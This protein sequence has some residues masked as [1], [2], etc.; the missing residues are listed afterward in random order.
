MKQFLI[1]ISLFLLQNCI[2][3]KNT[4]IGN[5]YYDQNDLQFTFLVFDNQKI[6]IFLKNYQSFDFQ[7]EK[8]KNDLKKLSQIN[9]VSQDTLS[10]KYIHNTKKIEATDYAL[11]EEVIE[12][13]LNGNKEY[14]NAGLDY[15]FFKETLPEKFQQKWVQSHLGNFEFKISF[16]S[17]L[18]EKNKIFDDLIYGNIYNN[19]KRLEQFNSEYITNEITPEIAQSL[20]YTLETDKNFQDVKFQN[21]KKIFIEFLDKTIQKEWKMFLLDWN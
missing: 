14:W 16:L 6:D 1:I 15:L 5:K 20:K 11:A 3:T 8:L 12:S 18:R 7:N 2:K 19:D 10:K 4:E 21:D 17:L 13:T 9:P